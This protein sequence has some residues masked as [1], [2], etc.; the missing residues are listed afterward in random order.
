MLS[1]AWHKQNIQCEGFSIRYIANHLNVE[2]VMHGIYLQIMMVY[3]GL[4]NQNSYQLQLIS[5]QSTVAC[6]VLLTHRLTDTLLL[7][8][9]VPAVTHNVSDWHFILAVA[10][11]TI[12]T[13][14]QVATLPFFGGSLYPRTDNPRGH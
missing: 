12:C 8:M 14:N 3:S 4:H 1:Q 6:I 10:T 7:I 11:G 5:T 2:S 13:G 9:I